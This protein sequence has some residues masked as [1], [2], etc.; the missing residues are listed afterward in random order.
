MAMDIEGQPL[1]AGSRQ[2]SDFL[3]D[4]SDLNGFTS[5]DVE[6]NYDSIG[7]RSGKYI[8]EDNVGL[9]Q[10]WRGAVTCH[11]DETSLLVA[12]FFRYTDS[13]SVSYCLMGCQL[14]SSQNL[15]LLSSTAA[16]QHPSFA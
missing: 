13:S 9:L 15:D 8:D 10:T 16:Q 11:R 2:T 5:N 3:N 12:Q 4:A 6:E 1:R 7:L 14:L